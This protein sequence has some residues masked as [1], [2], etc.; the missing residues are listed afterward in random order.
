MVGTGRGGDCIENGLLFAAVLRGLGY[1][2]IT[3]GARVNSSWGGGPD[4]GQYGP[5]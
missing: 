5:M 2:L 1:N 3:V 4:V